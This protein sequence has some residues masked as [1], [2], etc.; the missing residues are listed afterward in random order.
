MAKSGA[1]STRTGLRPYSI[2]SSIP[3][4]HPSLAYLPH[5]LP[6]VP[7]SPNTPT[8][9]KLRQPSL[10]PDQQT[11]PSTSSPIRNQL[12]STP[13]DTP[14]PRSE[15]LN[16]K[17]TTCFVVN[18]YAPAVAHTLVRCSLSRKRMGRGGSAWITAHWTQSQLRIDSHFQP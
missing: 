17:S 12:T 13:I 15:R 4:T 2:F 5:P 6:F 18:S 1:S 14:I 10:L 16:G 8:F 3:T 9:F 11:T 7:S